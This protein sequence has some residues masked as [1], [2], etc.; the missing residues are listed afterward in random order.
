MSREERISLASTG[1]LGW[2]LIG[3]ILGAIILEV[4]N[5]IVGFVPRWLGGAAAVAG[6]LVHLVA[7]FGLML[8]VAGV[9]RSRIIKEGHIEFSLGGLGAKNLNPK[10]LVFLPFWF[11]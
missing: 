8:A 9:F 5:G 1:R 10:L 11:L 4:Y 2:F 6:F 7:L 3:V